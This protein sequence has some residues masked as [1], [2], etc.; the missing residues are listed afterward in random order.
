M[1]CRTPWT[2]PASTARSA[3]SA[4]ITTTTTHDRF[5][6]VVVGRMVPIKNM[7]TV[8]EAVARTTAD[9]DLT[10]IGDGPLARRPGSCRAAAPTLARPCP[11]RRAAGA[12]RCASSARRRPTS[13]CRRRSAKASRSPCSRQWRAGHRCCSPTSR[14]I[15]RSI[16]IDRSSLS[17]IATTSTASRPRSTRWR[18]SPL[19]DRQVLGQRCRQIVEDRFGIA[20]MH[21]A[22]APDLRRC[23]SGQRFAA[24]RLGLVM[25]PDDAHHRPSPTEDRG[26]VVPRASKT[27]RSATATGRATMRSIARPAVRTTSTCSSTAPTPRA[28]PRSSCTAGSSRRSSRPSSASRASATGTGSTTNPTGWCTPTSITSSCSATT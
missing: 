27:R 16:S 17:S 22:Y 14:P 5:H 9:V 6:L 24:D 23:R 7:A 4:T 25:E 18:S 28:S 8:L 11:V 10:I 19:E 15:A 1:S 20:A 21:V 2:S 13:A 3:R 12:G 26:D